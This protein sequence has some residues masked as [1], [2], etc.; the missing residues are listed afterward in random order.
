MFGDD[1]QPVIAA[2]VDAFGVGAAHQ[3]N[4]VGIAAKGAYA[5]VAGIAG[6]GSFQYVQRGAKQH[7]YAQGR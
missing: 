5:Q 6:C 7:V 3:P 2:D 1:G 4:P